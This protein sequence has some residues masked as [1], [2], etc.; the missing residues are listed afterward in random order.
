MLNK[1]LPAVVVLSFITLGSIG[2]AGEIRINL[3]NNFG[4]TSVDLEELLGSKFKK[5]FCNES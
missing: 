5:V 2:H 4:D 1:F 3:Q